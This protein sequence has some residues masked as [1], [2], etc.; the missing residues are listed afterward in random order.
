MFSVPTNSDSLLS[1]QRLQTNQR[2]AVRAFEQMPR[3]RLGASAELELAHAGQNLGSNH[4]HLAA[5]L[6]A[7][8]AVAA[9]PSNGHHPLGLDGN[10][11]PSTRRV[12]LP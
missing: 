7:P 9:I 11:D 5:T 2:R 8:E 1:L 12:R 4:L 3:F 6:L 10:L